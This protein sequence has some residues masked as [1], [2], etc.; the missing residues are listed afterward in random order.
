MFTGL[1]EATGRVET[2]QV[3]ADGARL[4]VATPL[5]ADLAPGDSI[6][7]NGTCLTAIAPDA[8][9]FSA[10][11]SP[12]TLAVTSL[13]RLGPGRLVNLERPVR[14]DSRMGGHF[15]LGHVDATGTILDLSRE[16]D[17]WRLVVEV[18]ADLESLVIPRGSIAVDGISLTI[19]AIDG[20]RITLQ[21]IPFTFAHTTLSQASPGDLVNLEA[22]VL[23]KYVLRA[24]EAR[25]S[26]DRPLPGVTS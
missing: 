17:A 4:R 13:G 22:D 1:I 10:D 14:A 24:L 16:G 23:G 12:V 26:A 19:A 21:I 6:S 3:T 20:R 7:V 8:Q 11:V 18:P 9:G 25:T 5:G 2:L 15:V